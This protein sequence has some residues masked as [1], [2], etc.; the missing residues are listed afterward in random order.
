[1]LSR[2][3]LFEVA[4]LLIYRCVV[5]SNRSLFELLGL[6]G[7]IHEKVKF[8]IFRREQINN[9]HRKTDYNNECF[10]E[11]SV[12]LPEMLFSVMR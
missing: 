10:T 9:P 3:V 6:R 2:E 12:T 8:R 7:M 5:P 11:S 4:I 1:V